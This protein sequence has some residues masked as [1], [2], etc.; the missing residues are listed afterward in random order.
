MI[1]CYMIDTWHVWCA[2][3]GEEE[4]DEDEEDEMVMPMHMVLMGEVLLVAAVHSYRLP[5]GGKLPRV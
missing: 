1:E 5:V 2:C 3:H 4:E